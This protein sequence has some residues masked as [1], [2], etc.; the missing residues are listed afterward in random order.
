MKSHLRAF[1]FLATVPLVQAGRDRGSPIASLSV[2]SLNFGN[3]ALHSTQVLS[4]ALKNNADSASLNLGSI[5][6]QGSPDFTKNNG[7]AASL[8]PQS[9]CN[10]L[11]TFVPSAGGLESATLI[12]T[13]NS[14]GVPGTVQTVALS[15]TGTLAPPSLVFS[16][17]SLAFS[18]TAVDGSARTETVTVT[19]KGQQP[20]VFT[21][22]LLAGANAT[23][24]HLVAGSGT[25]QSLGTVAAGASCT[26]PM[27]FAPAG[28]SGILRNAS[29]VISDTM[30]ERA[31]RRL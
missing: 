18:P 7:C 21:S 11:V 5:R 2:R 29:L 23:D 27:S 20:G 31:L 10:V 13:D 12:F 22:V 17:T 28:N 19:N 15:G 9:I 4:V 25:C 6:I 16:T 3:Q 26:F 1:L 8:P 30:V 14:G 24:F